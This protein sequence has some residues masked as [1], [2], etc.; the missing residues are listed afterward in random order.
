MVRSADEVMEIAKRTVGLIA[1]RI[2]VLEAW[3]FGSYVEGEP[4]EYSDIDLA[5]F[6]P[7]VDH[8][9]FMERV[10][11][12]V[13]VEME[14]NAEVEVHLYPEAGLRNARPSNMFGHVRLTGRRVA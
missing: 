4:D 6:S 9:G 10:E 3:L 7:A 13:A 14:A 2:P 1:R 5:V 12:E 11:L 8:M